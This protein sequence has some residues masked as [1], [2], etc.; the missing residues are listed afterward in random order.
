M[1]RVMSEQ[2]FEHLEQQVDRLVERCQRLQNENQKLLKR[3]AEW[4]SE[5]AQLLQTRDS[6]R[7]K[8]EAMISRLKA[9]EQQ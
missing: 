9:M 6:T 1:D 5:R 8:V 7:S 3:E 4:K 2:I